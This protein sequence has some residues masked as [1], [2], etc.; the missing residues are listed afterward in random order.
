MATYSMMANLTIC[1]IIFLVAFPL[2]IEFSHFFIYTLVL[3]PLEIT[4]VFSFI[5]PARIYSDAEVGAYD[6]KMNNV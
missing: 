1:R 3:R 2:D 5:H 6:V 4:F